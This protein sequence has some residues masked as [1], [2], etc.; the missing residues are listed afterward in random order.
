[1]VQSN[2]SSFNQDYCHENGDAMSRIPMG[3]VL[4]RNV[5]RHTDAHNKIQEESEMWKMRD[6]E[7]QAPG[8][9]VMLHRRT[10][11]HMRRGHMHCDRFLDE[12]S[13]STRDRSEE[14]ETRYWTRKLYDF[15]A[16]DPNRWGHSGFKELYP[17]EFEPG[18]GKERSD[19]EI[20]RLRRR[21]CEGGLT[22]ERH[23]RSKKKSSRKKKKKKEKKRRKAEEGEEE[24]EREEEEGGGRGGRSSS[25]ERSA[26]DRHR[27]RRKGGKSKH[28]RRKRKEREE[29]GGRR[30]ESSS[31]DSDSEGEG[32]GGVGGAGR[33]EEAQETPRRRGGVGQR[34]P[35]PGR[36]AQE[37]EEGLE[38][39]QG[40][41]LRGEHGGLSAAGDRHV[42]GLPTSSSSSPSHNTTP[43]TPAAAHKELQRPQ[44]SLVLSVRRRDPP[45]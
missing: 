23:K 31:G 42:C 4:L 44:T 37:K 7:R 32:G 2:K 20:Q 1:M 40:G 19:G 25:A 11:A 16:S 29:R 10:P 22:G 27:R 39:H 21:R 33:P 9:P 3:K 38:G 41:E 28:R 36:A 5:I 8:D 18:G 30:E 24:E 6:M 35:R 17:E 45:V 14:Q 43:S 15:E 12:S 13:A 34:G 26:G